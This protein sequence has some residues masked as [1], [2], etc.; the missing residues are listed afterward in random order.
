MQTAKNIYFSIPH[1][2]FRKAKEILTAMR[3]KKELPK[4]VILEHYLNIVELGKVIFGFEA[5]S[6]KFFGKLA[7]EL[8]KVQIARLVAV[9]PSPLKHKPTDNNKLVSLKKTLLYK[10]Y[11]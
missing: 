4:E 10:E 6:K 8:S 5:A 11:P 9:L 7:K 3:M 2:Y 1:N